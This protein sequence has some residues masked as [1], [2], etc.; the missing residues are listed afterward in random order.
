MK[1]DWL[2]KLQ[3]LFAGN[4]KHELAKKNN[5]YD[6]IFQS[7]SDAYFVYSKETQEVFETNKMAT[8]LFELPEGKN[9]NGLYMSQ[10]MMRFLSG[11]SP[12]LDI[13]MNN[14]TE[15]WTG[16]AE[17]KTHTK[18]KFYGLVN[19]NILS[20]FIDE[21]EYQVLS[22]RDI[23]ER[24]QTR[25][26]AAR[27][28]MKA[29]NAINSK[30]RFLSSM[31]H[32]LRTPL[33]GIIGASGLILS[34]PD[35]QEDIKNHVNVIRYSSEHMLH[36]IND[37]LDFSKLDAKKIEL[38]EAP[39]SILNCLKNVLSSFALQYK[40]KDIDFISNFPENELGGIKIISDE[41][42]IC[43]VIN[44]LL[45]NSL[46]FTHNGR[47]E[48]I[49]KIKESTD[50]KI[51]LYFEIKDTGIGIAKD[52]QEEIFQAFSQVYSDDLKRRYGGTGL[53]LTISRQLVNLLG[54]TLEVDSELQ[55]GS[56][57]YFTISFKIAAP[58]VPKIKSNISFTETARDIRGV[59]IL[60]VEDNE[61]NAK[62]LK[63][64]LSKWQI[65][66]KEAIT[67]IHAIELIK[68]HK[69]DL[70]LMDLEMPEMNG[71]TTLKKIREMKIDTP[72]IAF[73]ATLLENMDSLV[74]EAGF[75][76]Y[77]L[78]PFRPS[79]LKKKI[80]MYCERK[81]DYA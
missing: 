12:N 16:E 79:D 34:E 77:V 21:K 39:F 15:S 59:R 80:E 64:F 4:K 43:Q 48:F 63:S 3:R 36:I 74:T 13:L 35:L 76:D 70:I 81:V 75:T 28:K 30:T 53:G 50:T 46:K 47:V 24:K 38:K 61:I 8:T 17:F 73:T 14:V 55:K 41:I 44:N 19:T 11:E 78:K 26:E 42:K 60:V 32:E 67:G 10:V 7:S 68:Y 40:T 57:F 9:L 20:S 45:S 51:V 5:L 18:N 71:Y 49:L 25:S 23:T 37:I 72:V 1:N 22:I 6:S 54:G 29:E 69:F 66:I 2:S 62:I 52:K 56:R 65:G 58:P 27:S 33:N 31:S